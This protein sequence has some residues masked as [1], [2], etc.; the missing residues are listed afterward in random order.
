[1]RR[2]RESVAAGMDYDAK[3]AETAKWV[4]LRFISGQAAWFNYHDAWC[5]YRGLQVEI[6]RQIQ[7]ETDPRRRAAR[8]EFDVDVGQLFDLVCPQAK[9]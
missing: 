7:E 5:R 8:E 4:D 6:V 2:Y 1:L 3:G 9:N